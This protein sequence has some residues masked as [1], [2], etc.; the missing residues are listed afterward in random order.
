MNILSGDIGGT[1]TILAIYNF[2]K[3]REILYKK[4]YLSKDW[5]S[6]YSILDNFFS[7]IPNLLERPKFACLGLAGMILEN[8]CKIT[9]LDWEINKEKIIEKYDLSNLDLLNDFSVLL[10][11]IKYFKDNQFEIIKERRSSEIK[12]GLITIVGAGTGLG[13]SRGL[14]VDEEIITLDS[15]GGHAEFSARNETEW[16]IVKWIKKSLNIDRVSSERIVSGRGLTHVVNWRLSKN[17]ARNHPLNQTEL[18]RNIELDIPKIATKLAIDGD[19]IM[20]DAVNIWISAYGSV[21]GD[22]ALHNLCYGGL[23]I[24]GGTAE[25]HINNFKTNLFLNS[26]QNKGRFK[27]FFDNLSINVLTDPEAGLFSAAC[28][29]NLLCC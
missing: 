15:E 28:R 1:K 5:D 3:G 8:N 27:N 16:Q 22:I 19:I 23:W 25:K 21:I 29:A 7:N 26:I 18:S 20:Q 12:N 17:D 14:F 10:Y 24:A 6:F 13:I 2:D 11:G 4:K 9:N